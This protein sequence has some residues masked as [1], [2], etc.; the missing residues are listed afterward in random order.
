MVFKRIRLI[1]SIP[2]KGAGM[3]FR[4]FEKLFPTEQE[5]IN[6]YL[7]IHFNGTI[8]CP[9]CDNVETV[10]KIKKRLKV[11]HCNKCNNSFSPF[12]DTIFWKTCINFRYWLYVIMSFVK[13]QKRNV[14]KKY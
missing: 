2:T 9:Y 1:Q 5:A 11:L 14:G 8:I 7:N 4:D 12:K 10:Y 13:R 3:N 6:H